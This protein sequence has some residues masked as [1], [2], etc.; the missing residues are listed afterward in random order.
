MI[1]IA[2]WKVGQM[3]GSV[4]IE[5]GCWIPVSHQRHPSTLEILLR[6]LTRYINLC[7]VLDQISISLDPSLY[8][9]SFLSF[10]PSDPDQSLFFA[11]WHSYLFILV[12]PLAPDTESPVVREKK[13]IEKG[14]SATGAATIVAT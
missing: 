1:E 4:S 14:T 11:S 5:I 12:S 13:K 2:G 8:V 9:P 3:E 10:L 7:W 6:V